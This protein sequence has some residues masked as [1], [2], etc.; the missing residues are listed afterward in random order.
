MVVFAGKGN[1]PITNCR[2]ENFEEMTRKNGLKIDLRRKFGI[3]SENLTVLR[4][5]FSSKASQDV[6][7]SNCY[8]VLDSFAI[9]TIYTNCSNF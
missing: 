8:I 6:F 7:V 9:M 3:C 1:Y 5:L 4:Y 2:Q